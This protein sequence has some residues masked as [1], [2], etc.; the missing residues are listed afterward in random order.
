LLIESRGVDATI[1]VLTLLALIN[2]ALIGMLWWLCR[3]PSTDG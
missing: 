2:V 1:G 3:K